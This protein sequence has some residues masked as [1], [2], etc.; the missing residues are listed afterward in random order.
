MGM[1]L[2]PNA[3]F[4]YIIHF[5]RLIDATFRHRI[6]NIFLCLVC[7]IFEETLVRKLGFSGGILRILKVCLKGIAQSVNAT[8]NKSI[9]K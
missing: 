7:K 3:G 5:L 1:T 4:E 6:R 2:W 9:V 8:L